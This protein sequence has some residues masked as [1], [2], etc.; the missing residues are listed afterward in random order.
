MSAALPGSRRRR[1][2][3]VA[4][5]AAV[6]VAAAIY[7]SWQ[8]VARYQTRRIFARA[9][10]LL[11]VAAVELSQD[12]IEPAFLHLL[13]Y[14]EMFPDDANGWIA[15]AD[16]RAKAAQFQEA[17]AALTQALQMDPRREHL[18]TRRASLRSRIGRHHGALVDAQAAL[19]RDPRDTEASLIVRTE[20]ARMRGA[21]AAPPSDVELSARSSAAENWP[22]KLGP[23]IR[24]FLAELRAQRWSNATRISRSARETYPDTM[25]GPWLEGIVAFSAGDLRTA[26]DRFQ[27]ALKVSPR[28]HRVIT[29]LIV[30][31]SREGGPASTADH[32]V[33]LAE[34]D[35]GF[36]YPLPIAARAWLEASQPRQAEQTIRRMFSLLPASSLPYREAATFFLLVD[37]ASEA[38]S[39]AADGIARFP[40][41]PDL[42][43]LQGRAWLSLG[44]REAA[45]RSFDAALRLR[46]DDQVAAAQLAR[47]LVTARKDAASRARALALVRNLKVDHPS[48]EEVLTAMSEA[49]QLAREIDAAQRPR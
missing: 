49:G 1:T 36:T 16:L 12:R 35:P 18:R 5:L 34:R 47:L 29:N 26:E 7:G 3:A 15:L 6:G 20:L 13:A 9:H 42:H 24:D 4:V 31:W 30:L 46:P 8:F 14:T 22:G 23:T 10:Q 17:E 39:T 44:D 40:A 45:I 32:L 38:I 37:R 33:A 2:F 27:E 43:L 11:D 41:D 21:D 48:D 28:S 25:L 19:E